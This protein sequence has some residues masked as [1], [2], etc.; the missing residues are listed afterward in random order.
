MAMVKKA[1]TEFEKKAAAEAAKAAEEEK[2]R[3]YAEQQAKKQAQAQQNNISKKVTDPNSSKSRYSP[4]E[5]QK[6]LPKVEL[7]IREQEAMM[8]DL[9][10]QMNDPANHANPEKSEA[11]AAEHLAYETKIAELMEKW[12]LLME[13]AEG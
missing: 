13:A 1:G 3:L 6:L 2:A 7:S 8:K 5:A 12:E 4:E 10:M 11:M 9:E